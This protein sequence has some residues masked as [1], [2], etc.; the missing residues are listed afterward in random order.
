MTETVVAKALETEAVVRCRGNRGNV[1][2]ADMLVVGSGNREEVV[3]VATIVTWWWR[4]WRKEQG[5]WFQQRRQCNGIG[6]QQRQ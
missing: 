4:C 5:Q 2:T 6:R 3:T 1:C